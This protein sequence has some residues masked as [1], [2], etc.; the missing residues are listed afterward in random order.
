V[1]RSP[2]VHQAMIRFHTGATD[3]VTFTLVVP[4]G[5]F[6]HMQRTLSLLLAAP[7]LEYSF[8]INFLGFRSP[9]AKTQTPT[10]AEFLSGTPRFTEGFSL[11]VRET[12]S[13]A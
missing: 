2:A 3:L 6:D 10:W 11:A 9:H 8:V 7:N 13:D 5:A 4:G 12:T 1:Q